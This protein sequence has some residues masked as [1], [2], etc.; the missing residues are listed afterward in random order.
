MDDDHL[1]KLRE[2]FEQNAG[3]I[4]P[5]CRDTIDSILSKYG[6]VRDEVEHDPRIGLVL[7][8]DFTTTPSQQS[9]RV[10]TVSQADRIL[11]RGSIDLAED[12]SSHEPRGTHSDKGQDIMVDYA[13]HLLQ[14]ESSRSHDIRSLINEESPDGYITQDAE[15]PWRDQRHICLDTDHEID[16]DMMQYQ[17]SPGDHNKKEQTI[18]P[19]GDRGPVL[20]QFQNQLSQTHVLVMSLIMQMAAFKPRS[21]VGNGQATT[22]R[23]AAASGDDQ[24]LPHDT[25]P[26]PEAD[27][28]HNVARP[29]ITE[30]TKVTSASK[31]SAD[32][33]NITGHGSSHVSTKGPPHTGPLMPENSAS[34]IVTS[35]EP[36]ATYRKAINTVVDPLLLEYDADDFLKGITKRRRDDME[37]WLEHV[38]DEEDLGTGD[39]IYEIKAAAPSFIAWVEQN[40]AAEHVLHAIMAVAFAAVAVASQVHS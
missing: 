30:Y 36:Q 39:G 14:I 11:H 19:A 25:D 28:I 2:L 22:K 40:I 7:S 1:Q 32:S 18:K 10:P 3:L 15:S 27:S 20:E 38:G 23:P 12:Q 21:A 26:P 33:H 31:S 37:K 5:G 9:F 17:D 8:A 4:T 35:T 13:D 24:D 6:A 34:N 16:T 29:V